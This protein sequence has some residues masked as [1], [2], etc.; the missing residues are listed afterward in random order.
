M[1]WYVIVW[2]RRG[3]RVKRLLRMGEYLLAGVYGVVV[4]DRVSLFNKVRY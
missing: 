2:L 1:V 3:R 4:L